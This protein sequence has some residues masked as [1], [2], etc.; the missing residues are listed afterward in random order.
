MMNP[1]EKDHTDA[2]HAVSRR[3]IMSMQNPFPALY[4]FNALTLL[5][6]F[7]ALCVAPSAPAQT[8]QLTEQLGRTVLYE[9][10]AVSPDGKWVAWVQTTAATSA[11][12]AYISSTAEGSRAQKID[13]GTAG[14]RFDTDPGWS[15][16]SKALVFFSAPG[17]TNQTQLWTVN[18]DCS[19]PQKRTALNGYA[20][21][22]RWS[23]DGK[24]IAFL[25]IEGAGG[26]GPLQA[27]PAMTGV[28]D[29]DIH[30]QRI[31]VLD[32][33]SGTVSQVSPANLHIYDYD[34]SPDDRNF[35]TTAAPGPGDNNWW[36]AQVHVID[37]QTGKAKSIYK[38][39][40]QVAIPR[41][42][43]DGKSI[44]FIEGLMSDE[45]FHGGDLITMSAE[46]QGVVDRTTARKASISSLFWTEPGKILFTETVGGGSAISELSVGDNSV[47]NLW[48][49]AEGIRAFGNYPNFSMSPDGRFVAAARSSFE[50]APEAWA[51]PIGQWHR[52]THNNSA[53]VPAWGKIENLDYTNEG[54]SV[55][56]W[57]LPP[58]EV[59]AGKRY[60]MVVI[61]HGGPSSATVPAWP[62][63]FAYSTILAAQGYYVLMPNPRGSYGQGESFTQANVKDLGGGDLRDVLA[64]VDAAL[65]RYPI[66]PNRL[67]VAGW[68]YGGY[69]TMWTVTQTKRFRAAM[70]G[71]GIANWQS[72]YGQN[73]IDQWMIPF[74]GASV[75]DDPAAYEK[76]SPIHFIK[77]V[78]T[79]TLV[80]VGERD[81][82]CPAVQS[83]EFWHALKTL[84]V[85][86]ELIVYAGEGHHFMKPA[87]R[88]DMQDHTVAWFNK[89]LKVSA[90]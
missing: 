75:Y 57:L 18:A 3:S 27:A 52:L 22:P 30:N 76:S 33:V 74:F 81:A 32:T 29:T 89:Y 55:Q 60:P 51:G 64:G 82:E 66:D 61:I 70:A 11:K 4:R 63:R 88:I 1:A 16:D 28:I 15:P 49:G 86:T 35:V 87:N 24:R 77:N 39:S 65:A 31:A 48:K 10:I 36:I 83:F 23:H 17:E 8:A 13:I 19:N 50:Q 42:S 44:A 6:L 20:A 21:R 58:K 53:E 78:T 72:Y 41:W 43:P 73:L 37:G 34:W 62:A 85:P 68:S 7:A 71:A 40:L 12:A 5:T 47:Q 90:P 25:Y 26:G 79:P 67:G 14:E 56:A 59:E 84:G 45:G 2:D 80:I 54:M 46:G 9:D 38:P 69:M